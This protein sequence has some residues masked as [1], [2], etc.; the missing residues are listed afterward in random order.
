MARGAHPLEYVVFPPVVA[1]ALVGG[2]P[3]TALTVLGASIVSIWNTVHGT[4]PFAGAQLHHNLVLLQTFMGVLAG[5]ALLLAAAIAERRTTEYRER[6]AA[7]VLRHREEMLRLAQ[8]AGGVATFEWDFRNEV[9]LCSAEFFRIFGLPEREG[10]DA[11]GRLGRVVHPDDRD[12]MA[13]HLARV[14]EGLEPGA[15]DYRIL[16]AD[17]RVRWLSY[18]G[19]VRRMPDGDRMLGTVLDI[20]ERK[21]AE[22]A[23]EAAKEAAESANRLK[24]DFL[25]TLSHELR[26]PLNAILGY[27]H[28]LQTNAIPPEK[29]QHAIDAIERN[30]G[31][32]AQL[33]ADLLD[34]S[35]D[36]HGQAPPRSASPSRSATSCGT[37][38][39]GSALPPTPSA[40][41]MTLAAS[42]RRPAPSA[43]I[44]RGCSRCSGTC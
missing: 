9:A 31:A 26:T 41:R 5:T 36:H 42:I 37:R 17:G 39:T 33:V 4:G 6:D 29:R 1:A 20:T 40:S 18:A 21:E 23:L 44:A 13:A 12:R 3:V 27:A 25:A 15:A 7:G 32:Q 28:M 38:S 34:M 22:T 2:P 30:A 43:P 14:L 35:R 8:R 10:I 11:H 24:D 19:Q 16:R